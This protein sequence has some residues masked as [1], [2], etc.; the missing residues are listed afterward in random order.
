MVVVVQWSLFIFN[1]IV[2]LYLELYLQFRFD[3]I[4]GNLD[5]EY[6]YLVTTRFLQNENL[7][8]HLVVLDKT[9][10]AEISEYKWA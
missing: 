6:E 7:V 10:L 8:R 1:I 5:T 2:Y 9:T 3:R 4:L